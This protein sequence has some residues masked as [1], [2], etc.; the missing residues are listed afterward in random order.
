MTD[1]RGAG[2]EAAATAPVR[3]N[4]VGSDAS[5]SKAQISQAQAA[6]KS[7]SRLDD[8][9]HDATAREF[10]LARDLPVHVNGTELAALA[11]GTQDALDDL[12]ALDGEQAFHSDLV[13]VTTALLGVL[14]FLRKL[15]HQFDAAGGA[16]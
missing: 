1:P 8:P 3:E 6:P 16:P 4:V 7:C 15:Q 12:L 9:H 2:T 11:E 10:H 5:L 13:D 14:A